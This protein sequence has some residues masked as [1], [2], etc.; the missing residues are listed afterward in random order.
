[1]G[2]NDVLEYYGKKGILSRLNYYIIFIWRFALDKIIFFVF[3]KELRTV[4]HRLRG[5]RIGK[6]V[7]IGHE[8]MFDRVYT[9][10]IEIGDY[11]SVGDR[12]IINAHANI[13][14][15]TPLSSRYPRTVLPTK[16]GIGVWLMPNVTIA[17]GVEIGDF[18]VIAT[19]SVVTK[20]IPSKC[21]AA[22]VPAKVVKEFDESFKLEHDI[23]RSYKLEIIFLLISSCILLFYYIYV[24]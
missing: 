17:P 8:V 2:V 1:M 23:S 24:L 11:S 9:D 5:V 6:G 15:K 12:C 4:L 13:P 21:L 18:S 20:D 3:I 14:S 22:G 19:G 16:I 7:Y 10:Q